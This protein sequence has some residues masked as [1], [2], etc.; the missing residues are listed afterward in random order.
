LNP[1]IKRLHRAVINQFPV[2]QKR[3]LLYLGAFGRLPRLRHPRTFTEKVNWRIIHDRR[4]IIAMMADK[5]AT[6]EF[7]S[8]TCPDVVVPKSLWAGTDIAELAAVDL[9]QHWVLK[10]NH[11][12][13]AVHFGTGS[14]NLIDLRQRT[15]G[16]LDEVLWQEN[17]QWAYTQARRLLLVEE[18]IGPPGQVPADYKFLVFDGVVRAVSVDTGRF[19]AGHS[20]RYYDAEWAPLDVVVEGA[21]LGPIT[22]PPASLGT[23][24]K[25]A[26]HL[27]GELDFVRVDLYDVDGEVWFGELTAYPGAWL[28]PYRPRSFD[29]ELGGHWQLPPLST[30]SASD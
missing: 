10:P 12:T 6:K 23:M 7:V 29:L 11:G 5:L 18:R 14:P 19:R 1:A 26:E 9:P 22:P 20:R 21:T 15:A 27:G 16:W 4:P 8:S 25:V 28:D 13:G 17:C 2:P 24:T 3:A 30:V